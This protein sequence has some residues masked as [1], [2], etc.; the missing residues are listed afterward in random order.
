MRLGVLES[1]ELIL[2]RLERSGIVGLF[3]GRRKGKYDVPVDLIDES[4][5]PCIVIYASKASETILCALAG[6]S[7]SIRGPFNGV[8]PASQPS[9]VPSAYTW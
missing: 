2:G 8:S 3:S 9:R 7:S 1:L 4:R 6:T 5:V